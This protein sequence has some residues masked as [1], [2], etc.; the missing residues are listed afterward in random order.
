MADAIKALREKKMGFLKSSK[1]Y[2]VLNYITNRKL[3][4]NSTLPS[5]LEAKLVHYIIEME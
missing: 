3:E 1:T 2:C 4:R 5:E